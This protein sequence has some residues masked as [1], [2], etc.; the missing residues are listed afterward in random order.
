VVG[1]NLGEE[2]TS[3]RPITPALVDIMLNKS[4]MEQFKVVYRH[5]LS[6]VL[7]PGLKSGSLSLSLSIPPITPLAPRVTEAYEMAAMEIDQSSVEGNMLVLEEMRKVIGKCKGSFE[8][9]KMLIAGDHL[10][11]SRIHSLQERKVGDVNPFDQLLWAIPVLQLFHMQMIL[12]SAI[13]RI[14]HGHIAQPGSLH[15][16]KTKL[17]RRR[18]NLDSPCHHT[19]DEFLR[20]VFAAMV[21]Q[22]WQAKHVSFVQKKILICCFHLNTKI[23]NFHPTAFF[24]RISTLRA[25]GPYQATTF[26]QN[27]TTLSAPIFSTRTLYAVNTLQQ[28]SIVFSL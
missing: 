28:T 3:R 2:L 19:A 26:S 27:S 24:F 10:T 7:K 25:Q 18:L 1:E 5:H 14:H 17:G 13:L 15:Y 16:Y 8:L 12:C 9:L 22:M 23:V 6:R 11:V 21:R 4:D 20:T